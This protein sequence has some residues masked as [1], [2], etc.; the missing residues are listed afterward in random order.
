MTAPTRLSAAIDAWHRADEIRSEWLRCGLSTEPADRNAAEAALTTI[1]T[2][3]GRPAPRFDWVD[4][5][6]A[7]LPLTSGLPTAGVLQQWV[8]KPPQHA[9]RPLASDLAASL[10]RLRSALDAC[11]EPPDFDA[12]LPKRTDRPAVWPTRP[13]A[14]ALTLGVPFRVVLDR[15][16]RDDLHHRLANGFYLP[17][18]AALR[19]SDQ[20]SSDQLPICWYGQ[21]DAAWVAYYDVWR[22]LGLARYGTSDV[23][24]LDAWTALARSCGWWWPGDQVCVVADRPRA[25]AAIGTTGSEPITSVE[26]RDGWS[27]DLTASRRRSE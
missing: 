10:S 6:R 2:R 8:L 3:L 22:R 24:H 5:P 11:I 25:I 1:Y 21:Q 20:R 12:P 26:F 18:R 7:A 16:T 27:V 4:S 15:S 17:V 13:P 14:E 23:N 19:S 9:T